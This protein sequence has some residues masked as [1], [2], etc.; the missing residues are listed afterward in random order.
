MIMGLT[1][2]I[3]S[4]GHD[5]WTLDRSSKLVMRVRFPSP[6]L[7]YRPRSGH[8]SRAGLLSTPGARTGFVPHTCHTRT[9]SRVTLAAFLLLVR[10]FRGFLPYLADQR[11]ECLRDRPVPVSRGVLVDHRRPNAG[12]TE[13]GHQLFEGP[14]A[15][16]RAKQCPGS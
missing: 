10:C 2:E 1:W 15:A 3:S 5:V 7:L 11:S 6:A 16:R 12:V 4:A 8:V 14:H 13:P 9:L